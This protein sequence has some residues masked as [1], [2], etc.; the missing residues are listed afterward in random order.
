MT[1]LNFEPEPVISRLSSIPAKMTPFGTRP[2]ATKADIIRAAATAYIETAAFLRAFATRL[3]SNASVYYGD[4]F[5]L[6]VMEADSSI[7]GS[8]PAVGVL[9]IDLAKAA[10]SEE[11]PDAPFLALRLNDGQIIDAIP[12]D[13]GSY[14]EVL[15]FSL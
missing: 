12:A 11:I 9:I 5:P 7:I 8:R 4:P 15:C 2:D 1:Q 13:D 10:L 3:G 14:Q 6:P